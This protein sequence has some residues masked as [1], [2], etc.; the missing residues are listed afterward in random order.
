MSVLDDVSEASRLIAFGFQP[1]KRP[2][3]HAEYR[4][5]VERYHA[6][7]AFAQLVHA[8][9]RGFDL[10]VIA[11][12]HRAGIVLGPTPETPFAASVTEHVPNLKDRPLV[13]LA[14]LAIA[15]LA[16]PRAADLDD[17]GYVGRVCVDQVDEVVTA[18]AEELN[19]STASVDPPAGQSDL[20]SLWRYYLRRNSVG[21]TG[22]TRAL[23]SSRRALIK[24]AAEYLADHGMLRR[25]SDDAGGTYS[26]TIRYQIQVRELASQQ[27]LGD[28]AALGI[29]AGPGSALRV[30]TDE[31][32]G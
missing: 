23:F 22:D 26:T 10:Q 9:V 29:A 30:R 1:G 14:H 31:L 6:D 4:A 11:V 25:V 16:F 15:A 21:R 24:K 19:R 20:V 8:A 17:D 27:M 28:L 2:P 18:A 13:L 5:L 32:T 12:D 7:A 3:R